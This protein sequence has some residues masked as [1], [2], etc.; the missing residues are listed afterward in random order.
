MKRHGF[1]TS[2]YPVILS[3]ENHCS[4]AVQEKMAD[5]I[6]KVLGDMVL[7][8]HKGSMKELPSPS[9]LRH[10]VIIKGKPTFSKRTEAEE[11]IEEDGLEQEADMAKNALGGAVVVQNSPAPSGPRGGVRAS[12]KGSEKAEQVASKLDSLIFLRAAKCHAMHEAAEWDAFL[13]SSF[14]EPKTF[15]ALMAGDEG[16]RQ[17]RM[18]NSHVLSRIYPKVELLVQP[19]FPLTSGAGHPLR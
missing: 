13:M 11:E 5:I 19:L 1:E 8:A 15:K 12:R 14:S 3:I 6:V 17:F 2:P 9:D 16:F 7:R 10:R 4:K 18:Y